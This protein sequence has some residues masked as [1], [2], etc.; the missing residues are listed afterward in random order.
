MYA[1]IA[2]HSFYSFTPEFATQTAQRICKAW[3]ALLAVP[4]LNPVGLLTGFLIDVPQPYHRIEPETQ[5]GSSFRAF[6]LIALWLLG[7]QRLL[8]LLEGIFNGPAI[9]ITAQHLGGGHLNIRS[10]KEVI[11]FLALR[12]SADDKLNRLSRNRRPKHDTSIY[13]TFNHG[14]SLR[15][16]DGFPVL[17]MC[18][19]FFELGQFL[20]FGAGTAPTFGSSPGCAYRPPCLNRKSNKDIGWSICFCLQTI[21]IC[22]LKSAKVY[23]YSL[24]LKK[25][26]SIVGWGSN[27]YGQATPPVGNDFIAVTTG[28]RHSLAIRKEP[29]L[30]QLVGDLNDDC[31]V[32][33]L[34]YAIMAENWLIDCNLNSE[35]PVCIPK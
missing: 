1:R 28:H 15:K 12:V 11:F 34:D 17:N 29:C 18:G 16:D 22:R 14:A 26:G 31:R 3:G 25:D 24:A 19:H 8:G 13:Q 6:C 7:S 35:N 30:Y 32:D 33:F 9:T 21:K 5:S 2:E 23:S 20:S 4:R 27:L 10:K